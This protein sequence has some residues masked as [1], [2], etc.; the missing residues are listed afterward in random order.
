MSM[1]ADTN[2]GLRWVQRGSPASPVVARALRILHARGEQLWMAPQNFV[3]FWSVATRPIPVNG[4]DLSC[5][6]ANELLRR[7]ESVFGILPE[8]PEVQLIWRNLVLIH[9]VRGRKVHDARLVAFMMAHGIK[10]I[11]TFNGSD[12][13]RYPE[14]TAIDPSTIV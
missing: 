9:D 12:F 7:V 14:I 2:I 10:N 1:F 5:I 13:A 3:E 4:L 11:L 6:R 8:L